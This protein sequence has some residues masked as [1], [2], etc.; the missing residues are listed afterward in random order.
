FLV[1]WEPPH[2]PVCSPCESHSF[3]LALEGSQ[4]CRAVIFLPAQFPQNPANLA[5]FPQFSRKGELRKW[6]VFYRNAYKLLTRSCLGCKRSRV[7]IP[8]ARPNPSKSYRL[9]TRPKCRFGVQL[10]SKNGRH[11]RAR[12]CCGAL[13]LLLFQRV[14]SSTL[15]I[16]EKT[17]Q[18]R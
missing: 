14:I 16:A 1:F 12:A 7:Q 4:P 9:T 3:R 6:F 13:L 15:S 5:Q 10:E 11:L 18:T 2:E 8:A 17:R